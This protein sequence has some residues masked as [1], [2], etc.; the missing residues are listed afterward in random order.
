M[1]WARAASPTGRRVLADLKAL[2]ALRRG[3][4]AFRADVAGRLL[5]VPDRRVLAVRRGEGR[6]ATDLLFNLSGEDIM[7]TPA[8]TSSIDLATGS[9]V[10]A[11]PVKL[12]P[13]G[14]MVL[15]GFAE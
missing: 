3:H 4:A 1:D 2:I 8:Q 10:A 13:W 14:V 15:R 9:R 6:T 12:D 5:D 11:E 7:I